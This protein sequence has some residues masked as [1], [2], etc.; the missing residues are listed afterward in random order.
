MSQRFFA[1]GCSFTKYWWPTWADIIGKQSA[2]YQNW[3]ASGAGNQY[4]FNALVECHVRNNLTKNDLICIMFTNV[5]REDRY[6][7]NQWITPGNIFTQET[8]DKKFVKKFADIRGYYIRDLATIYAIDR[9]LTQIG[10][11]KFYFTM[12]DIGNPDQYKHDDFSAD[13]S[14]LLEFYQS[15]IDKILPSVHK[16][17]F[18]HD[19]D[20]K[21]NYNF[22]PAGTAHGILRYSHIKDASWPRCLS[23]DD[24][25][26]L[27]ARIQK[28]CREI[29]NL[30]ESAFVAPSLQKGKKTKYRDPH[31]VPLEHL[32]YLERVAPELSITDRTKQWVQ[33]IHDLGST[34]QEY[35]HLLDYELL[36]SMPHRW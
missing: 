35:S 20:S 7:K 13:I 9:L 29:F 31:P 25:L 16:T 21:P 32:E 8:Y 22:L 6:V 15:T 1:F 4:I 28:E 19:W 10:C 17:V 18:D 5:C 23:K 30:D 24:F 26:N 11:R 2:F 34:D 12:V 36:T 3:G 27:P 33:R 14:D